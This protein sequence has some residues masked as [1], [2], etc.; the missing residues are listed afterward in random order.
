MPIRIVKGLN[1]P[2]A[3]T[4]EQAVAEAK[5][6]RSVALLGSDYPGLRPAMMVAEGDRVKAGQP[7][8]ADRGREGVVFTAPGSGTV[9][10]IHRGAR[11]A[12]LSVVI[13]LDRE[14]ETESFARWPV[15]AL[16]GLRRD[17]VVDHLLVTG[18]WTALRTRPHGHVPDPATA[19]SSLFVTALDTNPLAAR[20]EVAIGA[21]PADFANGLAVLAH[22]TD[23]PVHLCRAPGA[24]IPAGDPERVTVSEFAGPHPAGLVGTH[25]HF[26]DPVGPRKTVWHLGYQDAI[27]IGRSFTTGRP[28]PERIVA[29]WGPDVMRPRLVRAR[30]GAATGDVLEGELGDDGY[31]V[32]SGSVLSGRRAAGPEAYLGRYHNQ[33][34]V[35]PEAGGGES[36]SAYGRL[37]IA[38]PGAPGRALTTALNGRP[39][40]FV[41]L[42]GYERVMPL[43]ILATP[44]LRALLVGDWETARALGC[45]ELEEEDLALSTFVCPGKLDYGPALR[46][47]LDEIEA[48]G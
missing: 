7:L 37:R 6:V 17:Q 1:I 39:S 29:L 3:G 36:F 35:I 21:A 27:A 45:L 41:P 46:A 23:G 32:I 43:D 31:R 24:D 16:G 38:P 4:P 13:T 26:L 19:P 48:A 33:I 2:L 20:P 30:L 12:L 44:L 11:R 25:V 15:A 22:L 5:P 14:E 28:A 9:S 10:G 40:A 42:G 8:F 18:L 47:A 34:S